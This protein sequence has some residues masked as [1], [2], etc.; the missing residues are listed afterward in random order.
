MRKMRN[1]WIIIFIVFFLATFNS[2]TNNL[3][4]KIVQGT[5]EPTNESE[6]VVGLDLGHQ[7]A[8]NS[9]DLTNLTSI[10][11]STFASEGVSLLR[12]PFL[13]ADIETLDVLIILAP[14]LSFST[15]E[16]EDV[17]NF[18]KSGKSVLIATGYRNQT[19]DPVNDLLN[20]YG[21]KF[22]FLRSIISEKGI[23]RNF[24]TPV[25][26]LT[27]NISQITCPNGI[28]ISF[29]ETKL[30]TYLSPVIL[31][32]N[33]IL[34]DNSDKEPSE[35]NTIISTLEFENGARILASGSTDMFNNSFIEPLTN[36][37]SLFLDNTNFILNAIK[38]LGRNT[39]I[40]QFYK[41]WVDLDDQ[42]I[43]IGEVVHGNV[44]LVNSYNQSLSQA[45]L[46]ITLERTGRILNSRIMHVDSN[47]SSKY[48]GWIST[49][50]LS[51]GYCDVVF[52]A[53]CVGYLPIEISS[54][55]LYLE[56]TFP[57]PVPPN[58][59][60]WGLF[61]ASSLILFTSAIFIRRNLESE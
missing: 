22:N 56:P 23:A 46:T 51:Y 55:R 57:T 5:I 8:L 27:E 12:D 31:N 49:E 18:I 53:T 36:V 19:D 45:R 32:F 52:M 14:T 17:E 2:N 43:S 34:L 4:L 1:T 15:Q 37:T 16:I 42:S 59:A 44:T 33:P 54:G 58:L 50:G 28:G 25:T 40:L 61:F 48:S 26:P 39:G 11:N 41:P 38:W 47:D 35:T 13:Y 9:S 3:K 20:P 7:N 6:I 24:T 60:L 10:L 29:N 21:L 30:E